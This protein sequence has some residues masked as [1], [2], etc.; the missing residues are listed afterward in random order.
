MLFRS[1]FFS[2]FPLTFRFL[3]QMDY[4]ISISMAIFTGNYMNV[5]YV[6]EKRQML[7]STHNSHIRGKLAIMFCNDR[8]PKMWY[9]F[10]VVQIFLVPYLKLELKMDPEAL[11][12]F[13]TSVKTVHSKFLRVM[14]R[15]DKYTIVILPQQ[16]YIFFFL[17]L[18]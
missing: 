9:L 6:H 15:P 17:I 3:M 13:R 10:Y 4:F 1:H 16:R 8:I 11:G 2:Y 12:E 7:A 14:A 5:S 18:T